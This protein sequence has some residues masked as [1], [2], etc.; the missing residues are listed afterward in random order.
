[1]KP[2][3]LITWITFVTICIFVAL[4][5]SL[6]YTNGPL[7]IANVQFVIILG[8]VMGSLSAL[9]ILLTKH[10]N[11]KSASNIKWYVSTILLLLAGL[12]E[13]SFIA[14]ASS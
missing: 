8:G 10:E 4:I 1:M 9:P 14:I 2:I 3:K 11:L 13:Y 6:E 12:F 5:R 7:S